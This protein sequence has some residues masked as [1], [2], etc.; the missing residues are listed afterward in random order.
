MDGGYEVVTSYNQQGFPEIITQP[1]GAATAM[2]S[3]NQQGFLI[4]DSPSLTTRASATALVDS[5]VSSPIVA[6]GASASSKVTK[7]VSASGKGVAW[8]AADLGIVFAGWL[9][10]TLLML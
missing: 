4:T 2:K 6:A 7:V 3:Y 10:A 9:L 1:A 5:S 8:K